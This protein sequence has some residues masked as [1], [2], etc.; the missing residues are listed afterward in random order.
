M[1]NIYMYADLPKR[2]IL[3]TS[4]RKTIPSCGSGRWKR[5]SFGKDWKKER[6]SLLF[7]SGTWIFAA[8]CVSAKQFPNGQTTAL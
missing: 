2:R 5:R 3:T 7:S 6:V 4:S 1:L 8:L